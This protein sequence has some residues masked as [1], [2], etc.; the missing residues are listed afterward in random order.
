MNITN[1]DH[2]D[3]KTSEIHQQIEP[4]GRA[5]WIKIVLLVIISLGLIAG[6]VFGVI[7]LVKQDELTTGK[8]RDIFIIF[9]SLEMLIVGVSVIVLIIQVS[10]LSNLLQNEIRPI[11]NSTTE[12]VNTLRGTVRFLSNNLTEPVIK[13]NQT[14]AAGKRLFDLLRFK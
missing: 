6:L 1:N 14:V 9:L 7:A 4:N 3:V 10:A 5:R 11:L 12:T 2:P 8:V 13:M